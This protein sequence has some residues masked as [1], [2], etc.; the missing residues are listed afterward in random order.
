MSG[1][2]LTVARRRVIKWGWML[3]KCDAGEMLHKL[4][5]NCL[6][7]M[8][9][10]W[11]WLES[12]TSRRPVPLASVACRNTH[13]HKKK[14]GFQA[15]HYGYF[16]Y[17]HVTDGLLFSFELRLFCRAHFTI[18]T[19]KESRLPLRI[20]QNEYGKE[21]DKK[22]RHREEEKTRKSSGWKRYRKMGAHKMTVCAI[23]RCTATSTNTF[24]I[25]NDN[26]PV[27]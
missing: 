20:E 14:N 3:P 15:H 22:K 12:D 25:Q 8:K 17:F 7:A 27:D 4:F 1:R 18:C 19:I 9:M 23:R 10:H 2:S 24:S 11:I 5:Q 13:N 16:C 26:F 6:N 21:A